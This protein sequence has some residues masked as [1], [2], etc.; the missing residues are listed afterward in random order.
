MINAALSSGFA[1]LFNDC[2]SPGCEAKE[3]PF[4]DPQRDP[5][6]LTQRSRGSGSD[7]RAFDHKSGSAIPGVSGGKA[8]LVRTA[9]Q[10]CRVTQDPASI[11]DLNE[12]QYQWV[13]ESFAGRLPGD[14]PE[15][16]VVQMP[17]LAYRSMVVTG[18]RL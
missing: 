12:Y 16:S 1:F 17:P 18:Q 15:Q 9:L 10:D 5:R 2:P 8:E 13:I 11:S 7:S 4:V 3:I 6:P 14:N